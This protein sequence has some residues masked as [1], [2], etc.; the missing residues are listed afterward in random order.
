MLFQD[1]QQVLHML[2]VHVFNAKII[3]DKRETDWLQG[4]CP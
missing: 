1:V 3:N 2:P 4:V